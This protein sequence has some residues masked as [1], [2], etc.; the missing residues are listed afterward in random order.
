MLVLA[1]TGMGDPILRLSP[2]PVIRCVGHHGERHRSLRKSGGMN[3]LRW[4]PPSLGTLAGCFPSPGNSA[5]PMRIS[6]GVVPLLPAARL[7]L[8]RSQTA[9][10]G[11]FTPGS[12]GSSGRVHETKATGRGTITTLSFVKEC[13]SSRHADSAFLEGYRGQESSGVVSRRVFTSHHWGRCCSFQCGW[14]C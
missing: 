12:F 8:P 13:F 6:S 4:V 3:V 9:A 10:P 2:G 11:W 1:G 5:C 7:A 14:G